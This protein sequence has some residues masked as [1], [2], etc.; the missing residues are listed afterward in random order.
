MLKSLRSQLIII[1]S[2]MVILTLS[3]SMSVSF[4]LNS[5][6]FEQHIRETNSIMAESL[7]ANIRQYIEKAY[8]ISF[9]LSEN[10]DII[11]FIP[12]KQSIML[13]D[14]IK[15]YPFFQLFATHSLNGDQVARS[16]GVLANRSDRWW[17]KKF[18][19]EK[20]D[21]IG[22]SYYSVFSNTAIITM[23]HGI[24]DKEALVGVLM[25]DIETKTLQPMVEKYNSGPGSY[26]Y[27]LDGSGFVVVHPDKKQVSEIYNYKT[28][29]KFSLRKDANGIPLRDERGYEL[30]EEIDF[31]IP[32]KL[33][34]IIDNVMQGKTGLGEYTDFNGDEYICAYRSIPLPGNSD[35]WNL[36]MVQKKNTAFA[37]LKT[38]AWKNSLVGFLVLV[39]SIFSTYKFATRITK[40]L[41]NIVT[42]TEIVASGNF[43]VAVNPSGEKNEIG[44]LEASINQMI[45]N[46]KT[47]MQELE[48]KNFLLRKEIQEKLAVQNTLAF[49]EEK[50]SKA[51]HHAA[52]IVAIINARTQKYLELNDS[53][54]RT[55]G[56][57]PQEV[58]GKSAI[59]IGLWVS[60]Q[61][62]DNILAMLDNQEIVRNV[63]VCW[64]TKTGDTRWGLCSV[65]KFTIAG[66]EYFL[67]VW[68]DITT[69]KEINA[70]L[71]AAKEDLEIK[72]DLRTQE[73]T[74]VNQELR[75]M[76]ETLSHTLEQL[77]L[78]Q[79]QLVQSAKMASLGSLVAGIAH[80]VNT[81]I[82]VS[83]TA[84]SYLS[85]LNKK[86][87][88]SYEKS[89]L[90][91]EELEIYLND[92]E[93]SLAI[94]L[95]NLNRAANLISSF[96]KVSVDQ[97]NENKRN[98]I[99][100]EYLN[101]ILL[102]LKPKFKNTSLLVNIDGDPNLEI[103]S[104]PGSLGQILTNLLDNSLIHAFDAKSISPRIDISF[105][106]EN[107][108]F[109]LIYSDNGKGMSESVRQQIFDPFFTTK[110]SEG[111]TG[112][113]MHI[114]YN[115][116]KQT[117]LGNIECSSTV[118]SGTSFKITF[119][120]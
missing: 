44:L 70:Q 20:K 51:F 36:I 64:Q 31:K 41:T 79:E 120:V 66:E 8:N 22:H 14:S 80:E 52:D 60:M 53:F 30:T 85:D 77:Q 113:G 38:V 93:Q 92:S 34:I 59:D 84:A 11:N 75:S 43:N 28:Q 13:E 15:H 33:K 10:P 74:A 57:T 16:S 94:L 108:N 58:I 56:Y 83:V 40:P 109:I 12:E 62:R 73:L 91:R 17:F 99:V 45:V 90:S 1:V 9:E 97:S 29:K 39:I 4:Y 3:T 101:E 71:V 35:P 5:N 76:N 117:F 111:G 98:F 106:L 25:S 114:V 115:I 103:C 88:S 6:D 112:L 118:G 63:E 67:Q 89:S 49:S 68:H 86:L 110:R 24:Y 72:V 102:T 116:V 32:E 19:V 2:V 81:P 100:N 50:Y 104:C 107:R 95:S 7:A 65:E 27:I 54:Y 26:A 18:L 87:N 61:E 37:F 42:T 55:F 78:T 23:I 69:T 105:K 82:G 96:K 46:L 119:P 48:T 47:M 21:Y